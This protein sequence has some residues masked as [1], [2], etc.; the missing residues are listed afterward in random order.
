MIQNF[1]RK[2]KNWLA[3][4]VV[5]VRPPKV[6]AVVFAAKFIPKLPTVLLLLVV[7]V[8]DVKGDELVLVEVWGN[9]NPVCLGATAAPEI[10]DGNRKFAVLDNNLWHW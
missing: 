3:V 5:V 10:L 4:D 9:V 2:T 7:V 1:G 6:G 8:N